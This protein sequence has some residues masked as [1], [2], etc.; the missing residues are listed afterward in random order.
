M[1]LGYGLLFCTHSYTMR[2]CDLMCSSVT[3]GIFLIMI[4]KTSYNFETKYLLISTFERFEP[5]FSLTTV[6]YDVTNHVING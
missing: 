6:I 4:E 3:G 2:I 5:L 1:P